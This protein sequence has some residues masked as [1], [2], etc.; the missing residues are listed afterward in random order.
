[1]H[2]TILGLVQSDW[3]RLMKNQ[4]YDKQ[5]GMTGIRSHVWGDALRLPPPRP[6]TL[7]IFHA[8]SSVRRIA[9]C[10]QTFPPNVMQNMTFVPPTNVNVRA[11]VLE[12]ESKTEIRMI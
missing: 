6:S 12:Y 7:A 3:G 4:C 5:N 10:H 2:F 1:M 11:T 9:Q 8:L